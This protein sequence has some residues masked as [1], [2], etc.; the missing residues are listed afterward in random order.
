M[1][2]EKITDTPGTT[3]GPNARARDPRTEMA[4]DRVDV[5]DL[6]DIALLTQIWER[7]VRKHLRA[8]NLARFYLAADPFQFAAYEWNLIP[9]LRALVRD[10]SSGD[11]VPEHAELVWSAK[12]LGLSRP[13][14]FLEPRDALVYRTAITLVEHDLRTGARDWT[15][16][17]RETSES[18][19][20]DS[21]DPVGTYETDF[22][23]LWLGRQGAVATIA[24]N[25]PYIVESDI[26]NFFPT[27]DQGAVA[28]LLLG[29]T[30]MS[31][32]LV[33]LVS[34]LL[35]LV[36]P[37]TLYS[38]VS[39][40]GL[41]QENLDASRT[42]AHC[43]LFQVDQ[44]FDSEGREGRYARYMD[45]VL[46]GVENP[47]EG[48]H[49]V[50]RLQKVLHHLGLYPNSSKTRVT[51]ARTF[52]S[53]MMIEQNAALDQ[54]DAALKAHQEGE[55]HAISHLDPDITESM[56]NL[57]A[58]HLAVAST[59]RP[60]NWD[61][62]LRRLYTAYR[63]ARDDSLLSGVVSHLREYPEGARN[64]LEYVRAF[65]I[66][67]E[68]VAEL[69]AIIAETRTLYE[70][71]T[72]L[73]CET[74]ATA[75]IG[76]Q[77]A[78]YDLIADTFLEVIEA[79]LPRLSQPLDLRTASRVTAS[80]L[81]VLGKFGQDRHFEWLVS[82]A[83]PLMPAD[84]VCRLQALPI[85]A[86]LGYVDLNL[87]E[88]SIAGLPWRSA[89]NVDFLRAIAINENRAMGVALGLIAPQRRLA[90]TRWISHARGVLLAPLLA[91][92][93]AA[94]WE[95]VAHSA[96]ELL[97]MNEDRL[98]DHRTEFLLRSASASS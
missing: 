51:S 48:Y 30:A 3:N 89:L 98:R 22:F 47:N 1:A 53:D 19:P 12:K 18:T 52:L 78:L 56:R 59:E 17:R 77:P 72:L 41:P 70:D 49:V 97:T 39:T 86:A 4:T 55:L 63:I 81:V 35:R 90:P 94:R 42:I 58:T 2:Q 69:A 15:A 91:L 46:V 40:K 8:N 85:L 87:D 33:R 84:S 74:V 92:S 43:L 93:S 24:Q 82:R 45:D 27:I 13:L 57:L 76:E 95:G 75:P 14:A 31:R 96:L 67:P 6:A 11:Y 65:P 9:L 79:E 50:G 7:R 66:N 37:A 28:E 61:R 83:W 16:P 23:A 71:I 32:D 34:H 62:V 26:A 68:T 20:Q 54:I 64:F 80:A 44:E 29:N 88:S 25:W 21:D 73:V 38:A 60:R 10:L 5:S 36:L